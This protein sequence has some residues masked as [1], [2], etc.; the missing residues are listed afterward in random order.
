M[1]DTVPVLIETTDAVE[2]KRAFDYWR[3]TALARVDAAQLAPDLGFAASRR[4]A[5][6]MHGAILHTISNP[7][8]VERT[9]HH[10]RADGRDDIAVVV[11]LQGTGYLEQGNNGGLLSPGDVAF[12][13][14]DQA[15]A[16]GSRD[17]YEEIRFQVP[18]AAFLAQVGSPQAFAGRRLRATPLSGLFLGYLRSYVEAVG[19]LSQAEAGI[20]TEGI[21]HLLRAL[22]D[23]PGE[24]PD[25]GLS[26]DAV[27]ALALAH[28]ERRLHDPDFGPEALPTALRVSR[29]R[30]Y[31]AF[32][33]DEGV[34]AKIREARL[35]RAYRRLV[36]LPDGGRVASV[37]AGCGFTDAAAFSRAFRR[38][39]GMAPRDLLAGRGR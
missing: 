22:A 16:V 13:T 7:V 19:G 34:A 1:R 5:L 32:T 14:L 3:S 10:V 27:R 24:R 11:L 38:R 30:L 31:A 9:A 12:H 2:P 21:L 8:G 37:M 6:S 25:E 17:S 20:A 35:D 28:I 33:G 15:F 36:A 4:V 26:V 29:S 39:F 23:A 18:R